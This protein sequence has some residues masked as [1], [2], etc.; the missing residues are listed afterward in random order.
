MGAHREDIMVSVRRL[1]PCIALSV[2]LTAGVGAYA[3]PEHRVPLLVGS[4]VVYGDLGPASSDVR[5]TAAK[6]LRRWGVKLH[7][8]AAR[9][10]AETVRTSILGTHVR[11]RAQVM[12]VPI[13]GT[14]SLVT[15]SHGRVVQVEAHDLGLPGLPAR[16][17][18]SAA[19][20]IGTAVA[21]VLAPTNALVSPRAERLLS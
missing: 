18:I 17:V 13:D 20:A 16:H 15:I 5:A 4:D 2:V 19:R 7:V 1:L 9:F 6:A 10:T 14:A 21:R 3:S 12:G 8:E 11:G